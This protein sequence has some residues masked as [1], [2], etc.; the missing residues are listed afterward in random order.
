MLHPD[1]CDEDS[2]A[3]F[4]TGLVLFVVG[5][6][7]G[8]LVAGMLVAGMLAHWGNQLGDGGPPT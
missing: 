5:F 4:T 6:L 2:P 3:C 8:M 7:F 1:V